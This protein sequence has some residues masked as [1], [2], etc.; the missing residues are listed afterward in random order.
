MTR[1]KETGAII[2]ELMPEVPVEYCSLIREGAPYPPEPISKS[3]NPD[4][5]V[6]CCKF[7]STY[8]FK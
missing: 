2:S 6:V 8:I 7:L 5:W 3:W 1:A 4:R